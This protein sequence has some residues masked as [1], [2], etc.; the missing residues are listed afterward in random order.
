M[1]PSKAFMFALVVTL[2]GLALDILVH[3]KT[4]TAVHFNYVSEKLIVVG[5]ALFLLSWWVGAD[6][7]NGIGMV[8]IASSLFY[9]YYSFAVPTLDR[10]VFT[11]D[12][13]IKWVFIHFV[14][15]YLPYVLTLRLVDKSHLAIPEFRNPKKKFTIL[16]LA[17]LGAF[18]LMLLPGISF[19]VD[20]NLVIGRTYNDHVAIGILFLSVGIAALYKLILI[21]RRK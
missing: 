1:K 5:F 21:L 16:T 20:N 7:Q 10:A 12:E 15:I 14:V 9:V 6:W 2:A 19:I 8:F 17:G 4:G 18:A 13:Q 3:L 11:L